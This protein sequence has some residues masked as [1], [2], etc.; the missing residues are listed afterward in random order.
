MPEAGQVLI[1]SELTRL[2]RD[3]LSKWTGSPLRLVYVT[4]AGFHPDEY[5]HNVLSRLTSDEP[6][7]AGVLLSVG[8]GGGL[9][10]CLPIHQPACRSD[11]RTRPRGACLDGKDAAMVKEKPGGVV[12]CTAK[13]RGTVYDSRVG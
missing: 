8:V 5:F 3:V 7:S 4:N 11:L 13:R 10:P 12:P 2:I 1:S 6:T 9:L